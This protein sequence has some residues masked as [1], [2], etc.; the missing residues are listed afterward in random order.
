MKPGDEIKIHF[1][2]YKVPVYNKQTVNLDWVPDTNPYVIDEETGHPFPDSGDKPFDDRF[3]VNA[4]RKTGKEGKGRE[5]ATLSIK[6]GFGQV[7]Q[8][9][10]EGLRGLYLGEEVSMYAVSKSLPLIMALT[11]DWSLHEIMVIDLCIFLR[12]YNVIE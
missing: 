4:L 12:L 9:W 10:E 3:W 6:I 5:R 8:A 7:M 2:G 11:D 1:R